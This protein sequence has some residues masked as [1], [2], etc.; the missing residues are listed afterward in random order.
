MTI[1]DNVTVGLAATVREDDRLQY[2]SL[3]MWRGSLCTPSP[4]PAVGRQSYCQP[5]HAAAA[6]HVSF[7]ITINAACYLARVQPSDIPTTMARRG[8]LVVLRVQPISLR[9]NRR[10]RMPV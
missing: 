8:R 6:S 10:I 9:Q 2:W 3:A 5:G 7:A 4:R 1:D